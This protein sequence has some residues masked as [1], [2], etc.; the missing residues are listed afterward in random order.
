MRTFGRSKRRRVVDAVADHDRRM[1]ALFR[2]YSV[3]LV[4]RLTVPKHSVEI[5]RR[6]NRLCSFSA[7]PGD[8]DESG[9]AACP[10][11]L[12]SAR[13]FAAEFVRKQDGP[14]GPAVNGDKNA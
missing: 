4:C 10:Q 1:L 11:G 12:H 5:E 9:D 8:H 14:N 6:A 7:I 3:D 2:R 13:G